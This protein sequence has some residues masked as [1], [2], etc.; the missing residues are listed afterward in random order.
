MKISVILSSYN[1]RQ[2]YERTLTLVVAQDCRKFR[3]IY[4]NDCSSD[5]RGEL[6]EQF[7]T[8]RNS[9]N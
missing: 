7:I 5:R 1:N 2:W 4:I 8:G 3:I 6:V 9:G